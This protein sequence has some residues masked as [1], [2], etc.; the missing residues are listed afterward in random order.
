MKLS[1]PIQPASE[2][3]ITAAGDLFIFPEEPAR[4]ISFFGSLLLHAAL[5]YLGM[6]FGQFSSPAVVVRLNRS[7]SRVI[8]LSLQPLEPARLTLRRPPAESLPV[9]KSSAA[10]IMV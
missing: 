4:P 6:T 3:I 5:V 10:L 7:P 1:T 9:R 8:T 2:A